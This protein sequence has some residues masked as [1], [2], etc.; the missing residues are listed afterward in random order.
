[1]KDEPGA[2]RRLIEIADGMELTQV[3]LRE[4]R[5]LMHEWQSA[6]TQGMSEGHLQVPRLMRD[7]HALVRQVR[8]LNAMLAASVHSWASDWK[9]L[10]PAQDLARVFEDKVMLLVFGKFNAG[11]SSLCNFLADRFAAHGR[12]VQYFYLESGRVVETGQGL[13]EGATETTARLQGVCLGAQLV[14]LDTPGLHSVTP[15]NAALTQRFTDS[16]DAV[17]WLTSSTSPG[18]VQELDELARELRRHKPLLPVITRSDM[19]EEDEIDGEIVKLLRNKSASNRALQ[20]DDVRARAL[21]KLRLMGI[22]EQVLRPAVSVSVHAMRERGGGSQALVDGG[23]EALCA[24]LLGIV[25]PARA[26]KQRKPAEVMLHHLEESV[27]G[28][29]EAGLVPALSALVGRL[30]QERQDLREAQSR[31]LRSIWREVAPALPALLERHAPR[32][33]WGRLCA[34]IAQALGRAL[35]DHGQALGDFDLQVPCAEEWAGELQLVLQDKAGLWASGAD[36]VQQH[37]ALHRGVHSLVLRR[38]DQWVE[39][40]ERVLGAVETDAQ[41]LLD[42]L[43]SQRDSLMPI[44][45][46]VREGSFRTSAP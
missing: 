14:L 18:Q 21:D 20:E 28:A 10:E 19:F 15:D 31:L 23:F 29:I 13:Q 41:A 11:K 44:Q 4:L 25:G 7:T 30:A 8:Q 43:A 9:A 5:R 1:M 12:A 27:L 33:E 22:D 32:R 36:F 24:A 45:Q 6:L 42:Y 37:E 35:L 46:Q 3:D 38:V 16:A 26:Y 2:E 34:E 17:L 40:C 39:P